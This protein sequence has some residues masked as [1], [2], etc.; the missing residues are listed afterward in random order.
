M[1]ENQSPSVELNPDD[2]ASLAEKLKVFAAELTD[3][4]RV[5]LSGLL[6]RVSSEGDTGG[7]AIG[8][9]YS[10]LNNP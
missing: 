1:P 7:F 6:D 2:A 4:E 10:A 9:P 3:G 8:P 5:V